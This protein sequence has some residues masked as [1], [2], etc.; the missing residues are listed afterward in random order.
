MVNILFSTEKENIGTNP[1]VDIIK[2]CQVHNPWMDVDDI[3]R[4]IVSPKPPYLVGIIDRD[5]SR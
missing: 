2:V 5:P 4:F 3:D 1:G